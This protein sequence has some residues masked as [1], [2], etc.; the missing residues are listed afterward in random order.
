MH[1][2]DIFSS[3]IEL[4]RLKRTSIIN[5]PYR[6]HEIKA[7][8]TWKKAAKSAIRM[9]T[10][11]IEGPEEQE[12]IVD[13]ESTI[14]EEEP[15]EEFESELNINTEKKSVVPLANQVAKIFIRT[16]KEIVSD[17]PTIFALLRATHILGNSTL[18]ITQNKHFITSWFSS[19]SSIILVSQ[20][21]RPSLT[22]PGK[23]RLR[24][25]QLTRGL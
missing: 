23:T 5:N 10:V 16:D 4:L 8:K 24:N 14:I 1:F 15:E 19:S 18:Q 20:V 2:W 12:Q 7:K 22:D 9:S 21:L 6:S 25:C 13:V 3:I 11:G 17:T